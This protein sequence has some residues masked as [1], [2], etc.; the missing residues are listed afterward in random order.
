M[1]IKVHPSIHVH[2]GPWLK[3]QIASLRRRVMLIRWMQAA[4]VA[5]ILK[6]VLALQHEAPEQVLAWLPQLS[7]NL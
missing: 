1:A 4:G 7:P 5:S 3:R 2:P 6:T